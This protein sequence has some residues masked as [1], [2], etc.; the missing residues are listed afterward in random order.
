VRS[1]AL[2]TVTDQIEQLEA[3]DG[4]SGPL[5]DTARRLV[6]Q[7]SRLKDVLSGS[8][9]GHPVH[10]P[11]T[12]VVLGAWTS[13]LILD[14][15]GGEGS[16]Q[17]A[18]RLVAAGVVAALPTAATGLS[19][20]AE[21]SGGTRRLGSVHAIGN[22]TALALHTLSWAARRRGNRGRGIA[23]SV[24][25]YGIATFAAWLGGHLSFRKGIGVDQTVFE[26]GPSDWTAVIDEAELEDGMLTGGEANGLDVLLVR[27]GGR[28][29]ALVDRCSHRGCAL[30]VGELRDETVICPCHGST[31]RL[32]G[33]LVKGPATASQPSFEVRVHAG[34]VEIRR[35][36]TS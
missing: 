32:D 10:P 20:W 18:D 1:A 9:L 25:G 36:G 12:D 19:D 30:H 28:V 33:T 27:A 17:A 15:F 24:V 21:L 26:D 29:H 14:A 35:A 6:P 8:W 4:L 7:E 11:L 5:Q 2:E 22:T 34:K 3:L 23:L 31:F 13:A 16:E